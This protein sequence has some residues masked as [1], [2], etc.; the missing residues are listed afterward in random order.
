GNEAEQ[1][2]HDAALHR[3]AVE[4]LAGVQR[5]LLA[6][7][8]LHLAANELR[9]EHLILQRPE[10][11]ANL[12]VQNPVEHAADFCDH[13]A[14]FS[15]LPLSTGG[16]GLSV[17]PAVSGRGSDTAPPPGRRPRRAAPEPWPAPAPAAPCAAPAPWTRGR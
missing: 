10:L 15:P 13:V 2:R 5:H 6:D 16:E 8:R 17:T 12:F 9:D 4:V 3:V 7:A 1:S 11:Q 14:S